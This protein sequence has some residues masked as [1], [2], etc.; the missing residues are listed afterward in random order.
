MFVRFART[1]APSACCAQ[2][3]VCSNDLCSDGTISC[4]LISCTFQV[5]L[6]SLP[7][8]RAERN[9][10]G[11]DVPTFHRRYRRGIATGRLPDRST[12]VENSPHHGKRAG[13]L[14]GTIKAGDVAV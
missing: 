10:Y 9:T 3:A 1:T 5:H 11:S 13:C 4:I 12:G 8:Q 7:E 6:W 2:I 14:R